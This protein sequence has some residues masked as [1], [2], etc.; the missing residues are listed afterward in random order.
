MLG[1]P[2]ARGSAPGSRFGWL[3]ADRGWSAVGKDGEPELKVRGSGRC[4]QLP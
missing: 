3:S 4:G 1:T 2:T